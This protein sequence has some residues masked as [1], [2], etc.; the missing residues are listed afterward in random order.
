VSPV[1]GG[2]ARGFINAVDADGVGKP[3][4]EFPA[5]LDMRVLV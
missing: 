3:L 2:V 4:V 1:E 5:A